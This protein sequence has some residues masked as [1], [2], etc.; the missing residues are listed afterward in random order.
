M[1][2]IETTENKEKTYS[3][4]E[5][6]KRNNEKKS[7][8]IINENNVYDVTKFLSEHPGGSHNIMRYA[9]KDTSIGFVGN[10]SEKAV[11]LK[12]KYKIGKSENKKLIKITKYNNFEL[13]AK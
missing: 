11:K 5:V 3:I 2:F 10:R 7:V 1:S 8:L 4:E 9:V 6:A 13:N 12:E